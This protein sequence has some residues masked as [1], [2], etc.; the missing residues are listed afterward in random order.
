[1]EIKDLIKESFE[2]AC[3]SGWHD[4]PRAFSEVIALMHSELSEAL[5]EA[6]SGHEPNEI[7]Y[8]EGNPKPEGVV[9]ELADLLIRLCDACGEFN[10]DLEKALE[11]KLSYNKTR[12]YKHGRKL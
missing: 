2:T 8:N 12:G 1:M 4:S 9:V 7:Y 6:R 10:M 11:I 5:E 3:S